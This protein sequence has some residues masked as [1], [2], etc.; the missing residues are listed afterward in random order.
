MVTVLV[1]DD[2][3]ADRALVAG[4]LRKSLDCE[5]LQAA[6]GHEALS[7]IES[8]RPD[9][10][11]TDLNMPEMNGLELVGSIKQ[12]YPR[13]PVVLMTAQGS[14]EI[15]AEA[16]RSGAAS[17][18]P[19][20]KCAEDL[21]ETIQRVLSGTQPGRP[22]PHVMHHLREC[23]VRFTLHNDPVAIESLVGHLQQMLRCLPLRDETERVRVG[24]AI[25]AGLMNACFRGNLEITREES[26]DRATMI[27]VART[28]LGQM[29][30][31]D[32]RID[33]EAAIDREQATFVI[34][35]DGPGFDAAALCDQ[36][37]RTPGT[38]ENGRGITLMQ[39]IMDEVRFSPAGSQVTLV[40]YRYE[41]P[42][43]DDAD[44]A[45]LD[46]GD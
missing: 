22:D 32:R 38:G 37:S 42:D 30:Y 41:I 2:A 18:V 31:R 34:H 20:R 35:D 12:N 39:T 8:H 1:V 17:Y 40:K 26:P 45:D 21:P 43:G 9:V 46:D 14:E 6:D 7:M 5:I 16:L 28:R 24:L 19:K 10:V 44:E 11:L 15:A 25:E 29:P 27:H 4:L 3:L 13:I 36:L 23:S 33:V